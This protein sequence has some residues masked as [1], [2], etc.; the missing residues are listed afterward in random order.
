MGLRL[1]TFALIS[2][3]LDAEAAPAAELAE[4][5]HARWQIENAFG[6]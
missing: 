4:L 2:T 1:Q 5:Y 3:L 6:A